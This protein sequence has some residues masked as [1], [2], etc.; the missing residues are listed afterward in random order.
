MGFES[1]DL[2]LFVEKDDGKLVKILDKLYKANS[3]FVKIPLHG[4]GRG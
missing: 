1:Q 2:I 4:K 3:L